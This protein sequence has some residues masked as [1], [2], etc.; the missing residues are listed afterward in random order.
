[1]PLRLEESDTVP[2]DGDIEV[3]GEVTWPLLPDGEYTAKF[4]KQD[5]VSLKMFRGATRLFAHFEILD[6]GPHRG[7]HV[8]GAW[9]VLATVANGKR[10]TSVKPK[11]N[12][13]IMLCRVL[14]HRVRPARISLHSLRGCVLR[15][16]TRT[17]KKN[18]H[19]KILPPFMRYSVVDEIL[20][21]EAGAA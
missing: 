8:Y 5:V 7:T 9:P 6:L 14:G 3:E 17:V 11:S 12:L 4:L 2:D 21:I 10:R 19:Q 20:C 1:M 13:N 18:F 15:I 16:R